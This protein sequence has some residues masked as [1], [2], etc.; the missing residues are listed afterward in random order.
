MRKKEKGEEDQ[1]AQKRN[2]EKMKA[3]EKQKKTE[4]TVRPSVCQLPV[5]SSVNRPYVRQSTVRPFV[6]QPSVRPSV[7]RLFF[8][9]K[10]IDKQEKRPRTKIAS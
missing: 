9:L 10:T 4:E 2:E 5:R 1:S 3:D 6:C 7:N 8:K